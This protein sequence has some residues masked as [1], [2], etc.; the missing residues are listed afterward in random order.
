MNI[1]QEITT[2]IKIDTSQVEEM[3][4]PWVKTKITKMRMINT[5]HNLQQVWVN[6]KLRPGTTQSYNANLN[7]LNTIAQNAIT[8]E[9]RL[10]AIIRLDIQMDRISQQN[11]GPA[12]GSEA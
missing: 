7:A 1:K 6:R 12:Y 2:G 3:Q 4:T 9:D 11:L 5:L 8:P 10:A